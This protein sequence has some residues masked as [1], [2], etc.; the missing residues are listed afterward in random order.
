MS[1]RIKGKPSWLALRLT[2]PALVADLQCGPGDR[3]GSGNSPCYLAPPPNSPSA[4]NVTSPADDVANL[5]CSVTGL[6]PSITVET[7]LA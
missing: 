2:I 5:T 4:I 7:K 3:G 6:K 1:R